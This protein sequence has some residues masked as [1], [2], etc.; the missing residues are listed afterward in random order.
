MSLFAEA[1]HQGGWILWVILAVAVVAMA[2]AAERLVYVFLRADLNTRAFVVQ[3]HKLVTA[4]NIDLAMRLCAERPEA[5]LARVVRAGLLHADASE[6]EIR[7]AVEEAVLE[8]Q[9]DLTRRTAY[10]P[11]LAN[12]ATLLGLLGTVQGLILA[13][14]A[15]ARA[16]GDVRPALLADG[17][18]L[19]MYS[20]FAGLAVAIPLLLLHGIVAHRSTRILTDVD[21]HGLQTVH[22]LRAR[23]PTAPSPPAA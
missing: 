1:M 12:V 6:T 18:S 15:V 2:I 19:A 4:G 14:R 17:I 13:F 22:W 16:G 23:R 21:L 5:A 10:L 8:V 20:T 11:M 7:E 3:I 9:P